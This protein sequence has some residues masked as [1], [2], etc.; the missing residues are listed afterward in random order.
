M[1]ERRE[2]LLR[3]ASER[4]LIDSQEKLAALDS[5]KPRPYGTLHAVGSSFTFSSFYGF[6]C[7]WTYLFE[8]IVVFA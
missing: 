7:K 3:E 2:A 8:F 4:S 1:E 6:G 5:E